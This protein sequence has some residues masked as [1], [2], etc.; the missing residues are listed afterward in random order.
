M[1]N[2][3]RVHGAGFS[4]G[5]HQVLIVCIPPAPPAHLGLPTPTDHS[6]CALMSKAEQHGCESHLC[7][8]DLKKKK[9]ILK[10]QYTPI[11]NS[12]NSLPGSECRH[13]F[14]LRVCDPARHHKLLRVTGAKSEERNTFKEKHNTNYKSILCAD[15][16]MP[17][18]TVC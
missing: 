6:T 16:L 2:S 15:P 7:C 12:W 18:V 17:S 5:L 3:C 14:Q 11:N 9:G 4:D 13:V 10:R 8:D 1:F